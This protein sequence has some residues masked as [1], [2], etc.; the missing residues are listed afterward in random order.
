MLVCIVKCM[1][2]E[3]LSSYLSYCCYCH[4]P[5]RLK[6]V[7]MLKSYLQ[8]HTILCGDGNAQI[9]KV[10]MIIYE[11]NVLRTSH[12]GYHTL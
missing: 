5:V 1:M 7:L 4:N 10:K 12:S 2:F 8:R 9:F 11:D 3:M 6:A